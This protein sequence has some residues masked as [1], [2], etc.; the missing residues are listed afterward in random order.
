MEKK[1]KT[2]PNIVKKKK[3]WR[4]IFLSSQYDLKRIFGH[5]R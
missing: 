5:T 4:R 1:K 3:Q 2:K